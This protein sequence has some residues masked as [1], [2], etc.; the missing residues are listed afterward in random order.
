MYLKMIWYLV[1]FNHIARPQVELLREI[2]NAIYLRV[3]HQVHGTIA[4]PKG[5]TRDV[6][7]QTPIFS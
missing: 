4:V 3:A 2:L 6:W 7:H 1:I 5:E